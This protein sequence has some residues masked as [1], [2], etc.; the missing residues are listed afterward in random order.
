MTTRALLPIFALLVGCANL[1]TLKHNQE[2]VSDALNSLDKN[3]Y[4]LKCAP[5]ELALAQAHREFAELE[6]KEGDPRRGAYHLDIAR[7]NS[8]IALKKAE[9]CTPKDKD[10]DGIADDKD[11]C[12]AEAEDLDGDRDEDGCPEKDEVKVVQVEK[13]LPPAPGDKDG[14]GIVDKDDA[15][16]SEPEDLDG[17]KDSDGCPDGD[18]DGDA[19]PDI[20]DRCPMAPEDVDQYLDD[21]GCPDPDNDGDGILDEMDQCPSQAED[22]DND[23]DLD[24]CPDLDRDGDGIADDKDQC[25]DQPEVFN[26][27][28]DEDGCPDTKPQRVEVTN[29]QIVIKEQIQFQSGKAII[30][31]E[32]YVILDDVVQVLRDYPN[33]RVRI[34]GH[35]DSQ[36]DDTANLRLSKARADAVFEYV[37]AKGV[38][39]ARL[40][41]VGF[42]ETRPIDTNLTPEGRQK[43]RRVE[44]HIVSGLQQ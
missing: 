14:D 37:I 21:D 9:A 17:F 38:N 42:G 39:P 30:R 41:T 2:V 43:N 12:P 24:G 19:I 1:T 22:K 31:P 11:K 5:E 35:T 13:P 27:Y 25:A 4:A 23:R 36:G 44:F 6:F 32:S 10:K 8:D 3:P 7:R 26:N 33:I 16:P 28:M 20:T 40:E 34:E 18:N 15:C 29:E